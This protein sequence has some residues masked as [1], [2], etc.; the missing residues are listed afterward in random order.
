MVEPREA[1]TV[2]L[3]RDC[4]ALEV[5]ML[6]RS[7]RSVFVGGAYV[8]PGGAVD[9]ADRD[10]ALL[11]A[12]AGI[13]AADAARRL[14]LDDALGFWVAAIRE[15]FE[16]AGVM[17][18][19]HA[20]TDERLVLDL[21]A[22]SELDADRRALIAGDRSLLEII[23]ARGLALDGGAL[24]PF[25]RW[26]TPPGAPRRYDTWFFVAPA[27]AGHVYEHDDEETIASVWVRPADALEQ[28]RLKEIELIYPTFRCLQALSHFETSAD[29]LDAVQSVWDDDPSPMR[30]ENPGKGWMLRLA[31]RDDVTDAA[32]HSTTAAHR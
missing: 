30:V 28:A 4:P 20:A 31:G 22:P 10:P 11:A 24:A 6:R 7:L 5:F 18:A 25:A 1:A 23:T 17:L 32:V 21:G 16:E 9:P 13:D 14:R 2:M 19:R 8:F 12:V 27:P 15:S 3:V 26:I 29:V